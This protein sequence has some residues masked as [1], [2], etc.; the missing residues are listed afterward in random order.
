[1][2]KSSKFDRHQPLNFV[3]YGRM[4]SDDQNPRSPDQQFET[5]RNE[6]SRQGLSWQEVGLYQDAGITGR[7]FSKRPG[8]VQLIDDISK[9]NIQTDLV[10]VET[11]ERIGRH[12]DTVGVR[13]FLRKQGVLLLDA[14]SHFADPT[15]VEGQLYTT[16]ESWRGKQESEIKGYMVARG[17]RD[18]ADLKT[19]PGGPPPMGYQLAVDRIETRARKQVVLNKLVPNPETR[20]IVEKAFEL[21]DEKGYGAT[22]IAKTLNGDATVPSEFK[23]FH[24]N[25]IDR[26]LKNEIYVGRMV[27]C[28]VTASYV[29]DVRVLERNP[30]DDQQVVEDYCDPLISTERFD[31]VQELRKQR[32]NATR[33]SRQQPAVRRPS[34]LRGVPLKYPLSGLIICEDC[35]RAMVAAKVKSVESDFIDVRYHCPGVRTGACTNRTAVPLRWTMD[36]IMELMVRRLFVGSNPT[37]GPLSPQ[38]ISKSEVFCE[39][40]ALITKEHERQQRAQPAEL[41]GL[42]AERQ[43]LVDKQAGWM[44]SLANARLHPSLRDAIQKQYVD[45]SERVTEVEM[46]ISK[47]RVVQAML[48]RNSSPECFAEIINNL[49]QV[50]L[51]DNPCRTNLELA[52]HVDSVRATSDG[53]IR[54]R[55]CKMGFLTDMCGL[56]TPDEDVTSCDSA[57]SSEQLPHMATRPRRLIADD[58]SKPW[59]WVLRPDYSLDPH[60]F[61]CLSKD[62]FWIDELVVPVKQCWSEENAIAIAVSRLSEPCGLEVLAKRFCVSKPTIAA[63]LRHAKSWGVDATHING[64][65]LRPNWAKENAKVVVEYFRQPGATMDAAVGYFGKSDAWIRRALTFAKATS[66]SPE[67]KTAE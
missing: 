25:T 55:M 40:Q 39:F 56:K 1:M 23:P 47:A 58:Q 6:I 17:K 7:V 42:I 66:V 4:S 41:E 27:R 26:W 65:K 61:D 21:A 22:L 64:R 10:I 28:Q 62:W 38:T 2:A 8:F 59:E 16:M 52:R 24:A 12:D 45:A 46:L 67:E 20:P 15:T 36:R 63:A 44:Q 19:W 50:L 53:R 29:D 60:R 33:E 37:D 18:A 48:V 57:T 30:A 54:I 31:R 13:T 32:C 34:G 3:M 35:N 11:S 49:G 9:G 5:I 43:N 51:N 14:N